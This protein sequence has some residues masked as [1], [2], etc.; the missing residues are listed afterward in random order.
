[1]STLVTELSTCYK[2]VTELSQDEYIGHT[3]S[4]GANFVRRGMP[5][6]A[7]L[8]SRTSVGARE[9]A[10]SLRDWAGERVVVQLDLDGARKASNLRRY[11]H[12]E[13]VR[14][15]V[16]V[17]EVAERRRDG[18]DEVAASEPEYAQR[19]EAAELGRHGAWREWLGG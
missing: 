7:A 6:D 5:P 9:L 10:E 19:G 13:R 3:L 15:Q 1:M 8:D 14:G 17:G 11:R 2:L 18:A 16:E 4:S 12:S